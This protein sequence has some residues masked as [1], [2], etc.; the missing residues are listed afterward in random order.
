[1][2]ILNKTYTDETLSQDLDGDI[3][4]ALDIAELLK[5]EN[6]FTAGTFNV[7]I[8]WIKDE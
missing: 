1:M 8:E 7:T 4:T 2:I 3:M 6:G 5:D